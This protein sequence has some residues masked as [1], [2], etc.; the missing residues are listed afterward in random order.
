MTEPIKAIKYRRDVCDDNVHGY[1]KILYG[2]DYF[3]GEPYNIIIHCEKDNPENTKIKKANEPE[4]KY[5]IV[6]DFREEKLY[7]VELSTEWVLLCV[8][9]LQAQ[10][11]IIEL[12]KEIILNDN[13]KVVDEYFQEEYQKG[14]SAFNEKKISE[15]LTYFIKSVEY[16]P[17]DAETHYLIGCC[18]IL[19]GEED[20][21]IYYIQ[22]AIQLGYTNK[23]W[24]LKDDP[25][26]IPLRKSDKFKIII[27]AYQKN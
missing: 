24:I 4:N 3:I 8:D 10:E 19:K 14:L 15:A 27:D 21:S 18:H 26:L 6:S 23:W 13:I 12:K 5:R 25:C 7:N 11:N 20:K 2:Y 22:K 17:T 16:K 1:D 9:L